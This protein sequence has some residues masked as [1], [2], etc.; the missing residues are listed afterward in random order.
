MGTFY[1]QRNEYIYIYIHTRTRTSSS[2]LFIFSEAF[3]KED[4]RKESC[5]GIFVSP[6]HASSLVW[7]FLSSI[8]EDLV[9]DI[10]EAEQQML[11]RHVL[12]RFDKDGFFYRVCE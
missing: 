7:S 3:D 1:L 9:A 2:F 6:I 4:E 12:A 10:V 8:Y 5:D 11:R